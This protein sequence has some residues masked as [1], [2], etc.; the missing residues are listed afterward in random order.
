MKTRAL[1]LI[2]M[3]SMF[4][5]TAQADAG[6]FSGLF[7]S[8]GGCGKPRK[9][10]HCRRVV[11]CCKPVRTTCC[12]PRPTCCAPQPTCCSPGTSMEKE[13][14]TGPKAPPYEEKVAPPPPKEKAPAPKKEEAPAPKKEAEPKP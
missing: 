14:A 4:F 12:R 9:V 2:A 5:L 8:G 11:T 6:F 13:K 10:K 7:N 1:S 3:A